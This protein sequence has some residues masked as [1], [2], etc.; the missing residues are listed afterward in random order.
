MEPL[1]RN[2]EHNCRVCL[3][4]FSND[5]EECL[6]FDSFLNG[7]EN[8]I[9]SDAFTKVT[10]YLI[11]A[12]EP[13]V[14]C[15]RCGDMIS[16]AFELRE[17]AEKTQIIMDEMQPKIDV[18][19]IKVELDIVKS[20]EDDSDFDNADDRNSH[21]DFDVA[22]APESD[23]EYIPYASKCHICN[24]FLKNQTVLKQHL[25]INHPEEL[26]F[27]CQYC[28]KRYFSER[29]LDLHQ[30]NCSQRPKIPGEKKHKQ[31][32]VCPICG[33]LASKDHIKSHSTPLE[34]KQPIT[35][36]YI[37][38]LCGVL[39]SSRGSIANH[40]RF[41]HLKI[42]LKCKHCPG[43]FKNPSAVQRHM[44]QNHRD[45]TQQLQCRLCDFATFRD[46]EFRRHRF[47][48]TGKKLSKCQICGAEFTN[49]CKLQ[50]HL[51]SHSD[52]RPFTC[53]ICGSAFK[54]KK[55]LAAHNKTHKAY[56]Y[57]CPVCQRAYLTNQLMR[58]HAEKNHP[59]YQMPPPG[60]IFSKSWIMKKTEQQM[61]EMAMNKGIKTE[62]L[63]TQDFSQVQYYQPFYRK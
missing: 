24:K 5:G 2:I 36:S 27:E 14:L 11:L 51:A 59:E 46:S 13:Q 12:H 62:E 21:M 32:F 60:T 6:S 39:T 16:V 7:Y 37:C 44:R 48:H 58:N 35:Q 61:K 53:E 34:K 52:A 19:L 50:T 54:T 20:N 9:F 4:E 41:Q 29:K 10:G 38:D 18:A 28:N 23:P 56:D 40:M 45:K 26:P 30:S 25:K 42:R 3:Q 17:Q 31:K 15:K 63:T 49:N 55:G 47:V 8:M 33:I 22:Y 57:E 43:S 1:H